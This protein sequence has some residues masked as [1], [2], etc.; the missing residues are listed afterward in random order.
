VTALSRESR[1]QATVNGIELVRA[2][3]TPEAGPP[4][5][6]TNCLYRVG[7]LSSVSSWVRSTPVP[8]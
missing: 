6:T 5:W 7:E 3:P 1:P 2:V 8:K 4:F